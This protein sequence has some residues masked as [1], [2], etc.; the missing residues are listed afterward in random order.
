MSAFPEVFAVFRNKRNCEHFWQILRSTVSTNSIEV[1]S[2]QIYRSAITSFPIDVLPLAIHE[3][4]FKL[5]TG[6]VLMIKFWF[7]AI[8]LKNTFGPS[9]PVLDF[10]Y[11]SWLPRASHLIP[12]THLNQVKEIYRAAYNRF[13]N[14]NISEAPLSVFTSLRIRPPTPPRQRLISETDSESLS[15]TESVL[16]VHQ[17][18]SVFLDEQQNKISIKEKPLHLPE[19]VGKVLLREAWNGEESCPISAVQFKKLSSL[20][21]TSC[22]HV[23]DTDALNQWQELKN[24][25]PVCRCSINNIVTELQK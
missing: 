5:S 23:F 21:V 9:I 11:T 18:E 19:H 8:E 13:Q 10:E 3:G 24:D 4:V 1:K 20:S 15:S 17:N 7:L 14:T 2:D 22:F 12:I 25:C 6:D 16:T